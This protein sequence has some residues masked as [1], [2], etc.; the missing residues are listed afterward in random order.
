MKTNQAQN[1]NLL[2][3]DMIGAKN[4]TPGKIN[5]YAKGVDLQKDLEPIYHEDGSVTLFLVNPKASK[6]E[7][8]YRKH[9][10][11]YSDPEYRKDPQ[12]YSKDYVIEPMTKNEEGVW[13]ITVKP[14][15]GFHSVYFLVDGVTT[16]NFRCPYDYDGS[17]IRNYVDLPDDE[18]T[19]LLNVPHGSVTREIF[20]CKQTERFRVCWVYT[21]ASY[22]KSDKEYPVVFIHHGGGQDETSWFYP[23]KTDLILDNLIAKGEAEEMIVVANC[24]YLYRDN[25]DGTVTQ[26]KHDEMIVEDCL[27]MIEEKYRV[28]KDRHYRAACGLSM[29]GGHT[30]RVV[31]G[32]T[33]L[34]ANVGIFSSGELF[35][36]VVEDTDFHGVFDSAEKFNSLMDVCFITCGDADPRY[37]ETYRQ[38][39][40]LQEKGYNI[41]YKGYQGQHE[42]NVWRYCFKDFAK[43][44]FK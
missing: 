40:E 32:H 16:I 26:M 25:G 43:K 35:P 30:R 19:Q 42:W 33:D 9:N 20:W 21:P 13:E 4:V 37:D 15:P 1:M 2:C 18:D 12:F 22:A 23:G 44:I 38:V 3:F 7:L 11:K 29:G 5:L 31:F 41:E 27:P 28:K 6:V 8:R 34:F 36:T 39:S 17:G 14:G 10:F 24:G